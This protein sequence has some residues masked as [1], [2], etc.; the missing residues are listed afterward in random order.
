MTFVCDLPDYEIRLPGADK[1]WERVF[2][3]LFLNAVQVMR[4][5][6]RIEIC[7][8]QLMVRSKLLLPTMD[9]AFRKT[10]CRAYSAPT[11]PPRR[12]PVVRGWVCTSSR[13]SLSAT[14]AALWPLTANPRLELSS[15]F[16][17][18]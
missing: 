15:P 9:P 13:P 16:T 4:K 5:P 7:A 2:A 8:E 14:Q 17:C 6:G 11:S 10:F 18:L 12:P 3:N 1:D